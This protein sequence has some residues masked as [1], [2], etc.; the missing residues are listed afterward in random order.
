MVMFEP[1]SMVELDHRAALTWASVV[2]APVVGKGVG[3]GEGAAVGP[4]VTDGAGVKVGGEVAQL[5]M[6]TSSMAM[7]EY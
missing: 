7:S 4:G 1:N 6:E 3:I 2:I 5:V